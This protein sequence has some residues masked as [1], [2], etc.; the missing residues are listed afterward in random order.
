[1][2]QDFRILTVGDVHVDNILFP[3]AGRPAKPDSTAQHVFKRAEEAWHLL[4]RWGGTWFL[5]ELISAATDF[6]TRGK[7]VVDTYRTDGAADAD[8]KSSSI[9]PFLNSLVSFKKYPK[10]A[11]ATQQVY[12][13]DKF[14]GW[15]T[16]EPGDV[17]YQSLVKLHSALSF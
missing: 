10:R 2:F 14:L 8:L 15:V 4:R 3:I 7:P 13:I 16:N 11:G 1:M 5:S 6:G 12:R 9:L 17:Y